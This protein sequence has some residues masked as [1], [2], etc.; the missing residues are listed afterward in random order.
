MVLGFLITVI[1]F[2]IIF[3]LLSFI[4]DIDLQLVLLPTQSKRKRGGLTAPVGFCLCCSLLTNHE[5]VSGP[6][7]AHLSHLENG[8]NEPSPNEVLRT[9][10]DIRTFKNMN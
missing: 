2:H 4:L 5:Q 8:L 10:V 7:T 3:P 6:L 1:M 9:Y